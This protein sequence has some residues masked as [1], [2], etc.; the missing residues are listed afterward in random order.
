ML[1]AKFKHIGIFLI[2][3]LIVTVINVSIMAAD[4]QDAV[5]FLLYFQ[6]GYLVETFLQT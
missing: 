3:S 4:V 2:T 5:A 6:I 1:Q